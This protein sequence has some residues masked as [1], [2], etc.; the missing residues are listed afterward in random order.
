M[1]SAIGRLEVEGARLAHEMALSL[2]IH[3]ASTKAAVVAG[4]LTT[5][6]Y[7]LRSGLDGVHQGRDVSLEAMVTVR[8]AR[9]GYT[10]AHSVA[11]RWVPK[12]SAFSL[13]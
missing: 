7:A 3:E 12:A 10:A 4:W 2:G 8:E 5:V 13:D 9:I 11:K 1:G 6:M